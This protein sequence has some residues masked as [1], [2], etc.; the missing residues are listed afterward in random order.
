MHLALCLSRGC[1]R[2]NILSKHAGEI[3]ETACFTKTC[4]DVE[5][6]NLFRVRQGGGARGK[7]GIY[8]RG[9]LSAGQGRRRKT[10]VRSL[11]CHRR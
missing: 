3:M 4:K 6:N 5:G 2:F 1:F 8:K 9:H 11:G 10:L 7:A